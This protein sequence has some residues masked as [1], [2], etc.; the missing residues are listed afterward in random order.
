MPQ[1]PTGSNA[2]GRL[3]EI[4]QASRLLSGELEGGWS[5]AG[6]RPGRTDKGGLFQTIRRK[7]APPASPGCARWT[8]RQPWRLAFCAVR[9]TSR[10]NA[11]SRIPPGLSRLLL[12]SVLL[13]LIR[14]PAFGHL[15]E[16]P[17]PVCPGIRG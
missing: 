14:Q 1:V 9:V 16:K 4:D 17:L 8:S 10:G 7:A 11:S 2:E 12:P 3:R 6:P 15:A 13:G 5:L